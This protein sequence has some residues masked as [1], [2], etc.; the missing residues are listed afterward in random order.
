MPNWLIKSAI[1]RV[2]SWL[3]AR[4]FWCDLLRGKSTTISPDGF[5]GALGFFRRHTEASVKKRGP[6]NEGY[7]VLELGTGWNPV[8]PI[9]HFLCGAGKVETFDIESLL[10]PDRVAR[11]IGLFRDFAHEGRLANELPALIPAR[12]ARL[13]EVASTAANRPPAETLAMLG[14]HVHVADARHTGLSD[15]SADFL[16]SHSVFEYVPR[17]PFAEL[18]REFRRVARPGAVT[19][20]YIRLSDQYHHFDH[21]LSQFNFLRYTARQWRWFDSPIIPQSRLR[22]SDCREIFQQTGWRVFCEE[23]TNGTLEDLRRVTLAPEFHA[24]REEDLM[25]VGTWM[26]AD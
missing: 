24:Y 26:A 2:V 3:P 15:A 1:H 14:I 17:T 11:V 5:A 6:F 19:S 16:F 21:N 13:D 25:V 7:T 22:I 8:Q 20:H 23:N 10:Q 4:R 12:L 18:M 9:A